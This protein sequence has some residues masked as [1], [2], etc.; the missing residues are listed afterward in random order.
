M[1]KIVVP[2]GVGGYHKKF[3]THIHRYLFAVRVKENGGEFFDGELTLDKPKLYRQG[4]FCD[5]VAGADEQCHH[6]R[7]AKQANG[8]KEGGF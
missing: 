1:Y 4:V 2:F 6:N 7:N 5:N 3:L 8:D